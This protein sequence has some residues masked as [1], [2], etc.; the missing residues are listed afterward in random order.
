MGK[1]EKSNF[2]SILESFFHHCGEKFLKG[3]IVSCVYNEDTKI[4]NINGWILPVSNYDSLEVRV[5]NNSYPVRVDIRFKEGYEKYP[6]LNE[7]L[8]GWDCIVSNPQIDIKKNNI[9]T[10]LAFRNNKIVL[11]LEKKLSIQKEIKTETY[12]Y[13]NY[14]I[15]A[16]NIRTGSVSN[17]NRITQYNEI[18]KKMEEWMPWENNY[19]HQKFLQK[20]EEIIYGNESVGELF[21]DIFSD[22]NTIYFKKYKLKYESKHS[23]WII[24]NEILGNQEYYFE[25]DKETPVIIDGGANIGLAVLYFKVLFPN[26]HIIA[27]EPSKRMFSLL[28]ENMELNKWTDVFLYPYALDEKECDIDLLIPTTDC[29]G[30]SLTTRPTETTNSNTQFIKE[31]VHCVSLDKFINEEIDFL[32][33]DIEGVEVRVLRGLGE[34]IKNAKNLF[35]EYHFGK[36]LHDNSFAELINLLESNGFKIQVAK[37]PSY[38]RLTGEKTMKYVGERYSLNVWAKQ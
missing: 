21:V 3:G 4:M 23:L 1:I 25:L 19:F 6:F 26:S 28:K 17:I 27:F 15:N 22:G 13:N 33:L 5:D 29:L 12:T 24:M 20:K 32:K 18:V 34:K 7:R 16:T 38:Q 37:S 36:T 14:Y 9:I 35:C 8:S 31:T 2:N 11:K 10:F 30:A